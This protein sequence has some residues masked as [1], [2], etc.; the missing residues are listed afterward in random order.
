M[1][2]SKGA[3]SEKE[4]KGFISRFFSRSK[5]EEVTSAGNLEFSA[6]HNGNNLIIQVQSQTGSSLNI[7]E[8]ALILRRVQKKLS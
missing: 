7:K 2:R 4:E 8:Q 1:A 6:R 5:D 3:A